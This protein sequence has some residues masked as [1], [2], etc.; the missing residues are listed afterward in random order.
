MKNVSI[1]IPNWNGKHLLEKNLQKVISAA[2]GAEIIVAD[3]GS[4]DGSVQYL[5]EKFPGVVLVQKKK[6]EGFA[7]TVNAGVAKVHGE[8]IVLLNTDVVPE[9][10]FLQPLVSHFA[11]DKVFAVG[12]MDKSKEG[13]SF[14]LRGRGLAKWQRGFFVHERG[15]V[16]T[17]NTVWVSGGSGAFRKSLWQELGGMDPLFNPFYWEDIDLSY[18]ARKAGYR[19]LFEPKSAVWHF[20]EEGKIKQSFS[21]I[22]IKIIAYRNQF[23]FV[24][25]NI[26]DVR[27]LLSHIFWTPVRLLQA[28]FSCDIGMILGYWAALIRL[29]QIVIS[30]IKASALWKLSDRD[31]L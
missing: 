21:T 6:H 17:S 13:D 27:F 14:V 18:R 23:T 10:N 28:L 5:L 26:S 15:E 19:I 24:W 30:R 8:I 2:G 20:H 9:K 4:S 12:C 16:D 31:L 29:P 1:V 11:D 3:D 7:S 25:K 22:S